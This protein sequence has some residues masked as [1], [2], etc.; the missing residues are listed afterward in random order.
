M[1]TSQANIVVEL[2]WAV[3][4]LCGIPAADM[5]LSAV[6]I[7]VVAVWFWIRPHPQV[8]F[9]RQARHDEWTSRKLSCCVSVAQHR[10]STLPLLRLCGCGRIGGAG[11]LL[12]CAL[13]AVTDTGDGPWTNTQQ[14][15]RQCCYRDS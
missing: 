13:T 11:V 9:Q 4:I 1:F 15:S 10:R 12:K 8:R 14:C 3:H 5:Y 2:L 6:L 7:L